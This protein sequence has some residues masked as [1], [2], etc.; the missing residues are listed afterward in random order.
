MFT[1][2]TVVAGST[3]LSVLLLQEILA[4]RKFKGKDGKE[5]DL[6]RSAGTNTI[7]ALNAYKKSRNMKQ[8]GICDAAV[9]KDL[10]AL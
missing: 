6:D 10:I 3:G 5:L 2:E 1:T 7:Y 9:W 8:D 4:A